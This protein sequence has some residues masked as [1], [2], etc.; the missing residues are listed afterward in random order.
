MSYPSLDEIQ[1][2]SHYQLAKWARNL[3]SPRNVDEKA[4]LDLLL[5]RFRSLGGWDP[6]LSKKVGW[7]GR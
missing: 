2:A 6:D 4:L 1:S 7:E 3:P 5:E